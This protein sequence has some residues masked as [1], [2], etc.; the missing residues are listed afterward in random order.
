MR[1][2]RFMVLL[3]AALAAICVAL[4]TSSRRNVESDSRGVNLLPS[5]TQELNTVTELSVTK[6]SKTAAVTVHKQGEQWTVAERNNYPADVAKLRKLLLA[7]SEAR[8]REEKTSNPASYSI[9]GVEDPT[10]PGAAGAQIDFV[11]QDGK[12]AVIVGKPVGEG[13]FVRRAGEPRSYIVEPGITVEAQPR[14]WID[15]RLIDL[16]AAKIQSIEVKPATGPSYSLH[17]AAAAATPAPATPAP[18]TPAP[19]TPAPA[20]P[21]PAAPAAASPPATA[22]PTDFVLDGVP[23]KRK[24]AESQI[25]EPSPTAFGNLSADDVAQAADIDFSKPSVATV[26]LSDGSVITFTGTAVGDKR[27]IQVAEPKDAGIS[28]K[29][30]GRAFEIAT[31][32]YDAVFR[33]LEQLLVPLPPAPEKKPASP[34]KL[35][36]AQRTAPPNPAPT[37]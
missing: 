5:L 21:A 35:P 8:I 25:L 18:A 20:T 33:P 16:P 4:Y 9:I 14:Y 12:H 3:V 26:T 36:A 11:A 1:R 30:K 2:Q 13:N 34:A 24:A 10:L 27:W 29:T 22:T 19:A 37:P 31:Y 23:A 6:G 15:T 7:L 32:R 28:A 17:R